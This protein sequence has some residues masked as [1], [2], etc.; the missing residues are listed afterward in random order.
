MRGSSW[1]LWEQSRLLLI[2]ENQS[3]RFTTSEENSCVGQ[4]GDC[5]LARKASPSSRFPSPQPTCAFLCLIFGS[6]VAW[7]AHVP[8]RNLCSVAVWVCKKVAEPTME[9]RNFYRS[10]II[11]PLRLQ[12]ENFLPDG[13]SAFGVTSPY[14]NW[15]RL[16]MRR[17]KRQSGLTIWWLQCATLASVDCQLLHHF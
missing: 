12:M 3:R 17:T 9:K 2:K 1:L 11:R 5:T 7:Y 14:P 4:V 10:W 15:I 16:Q 6:L 8:H 13:K